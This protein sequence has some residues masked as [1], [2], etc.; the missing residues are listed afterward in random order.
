MS[1]VRRALQRTA[2]TLPFLLRE[3]HTDNGSEFINHSLRLV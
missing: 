2:V 3:L 1:R